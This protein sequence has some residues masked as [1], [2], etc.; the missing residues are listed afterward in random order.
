MDPQYDHHTHC[1]I[2]NGPQVYLCANQKRARKS[3]LVLVEYAKCL[4]G[5]EVVMTVNI[6]N[7]PWT[8][9]LC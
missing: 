9:N 7:L 6:I 8:L 2:H 3:H 4:K 5:N 1:D